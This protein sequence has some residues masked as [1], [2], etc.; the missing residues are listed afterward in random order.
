MFYL[1]FPLAV[2]GYWIWVLPLVVLFGVIWALETTENYDGSSISNPNSFAAGMFILIGLAVLICLTDVPVLS[3]LHAN[4]SYVLIGAVAY[5]LFG[6]AWAFVHWVVFFIR[7]RAD[8]YEK[9]RTEIKGDYDRRSK[10]GRL[11]PTK[12]SYADFA[13][14]NYHFPPMPTENK[15]R[16]TSWMLYWPADLLWTML[17]KAVKRL[18]NWIYDCLANTLATISKNM[19]AKRFEEFK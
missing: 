14:V 19:F 11:D 10:D 3:W 17:H 4:Y 8:R 15:A 16:I 18:Y 13:Q 5:V 6:A 9:L 12:L 7:E 2:I 1:L